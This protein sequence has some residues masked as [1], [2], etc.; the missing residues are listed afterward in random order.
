MKSRAAVTVGDR[1]I[2]LRTVAVPERPP[3]GG[4]LLRV[5]ANGL[6]GSD[7]DLYSGHLRAASPALVPLPLVSGHEMVGVLERVDPEAAEK[8]DVRAGDR[9]VVDPAVRCGQCMDCRSSTDNRCRDLLRYSTMPLSRGSGLW[10]GNAEYMELLA[11]TLVV[12]VPD[13][14]S[15]EDATLYNPLG[16]AIHWLVTVAGVRPGDSVLILGA[17][18]RGFACSAVAHNAGAATVIVTGLER[19]QAKAP[20]LARFGADALIDAETGDT[21]AQVLE[22]TGGEGVDIVVDTV[23][24]TAT[25][26]R[27]GLA[28]LKRGGRLVVAGI[29]AA[30]TDGLDINAIT[31]R[32]LVV[33]GVFGS[34]TFGV[35]R[36][37]RML[38]E[39]RYPFAELHTHRFGLDELDEALRVLGGE[40]PGERPLHL[41]IVP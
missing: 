15:D 10:G 35:R 2:E 40:V 26:T 7:Y 38:T 12:R 5:T 3:R 17:G 37:V 39:A 23:P 6:C 27:D 19:D 22:L 4:A 33:R 31:L 13:G 41:T 36:A 28:C 34:S 8:W 24:G 29:K 11:G 20:L 21:T 1:E 9:V 30:A 18:Q 14:L 32:E 25:S 16:N